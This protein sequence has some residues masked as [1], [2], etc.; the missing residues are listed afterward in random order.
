MEFV[1][2]GLRG[3]ILDETPMIALTTIIVPAAYAPATFYWTGC[4]RQRTILDS[5]VHRRRAYQPAE[6]HSPKHRRD[7]AIGEDGGRSKGERG[8]IW[9]SDPKPQESRSPK[10]AEETYPTLYRKKLRRVQPR[11]RAKETMRRGM[12]RRGAERESRRFC[13]RFIS[14]ATL[15]YP[16]YSDGRK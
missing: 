5:K 9:S 2:C 4:P 1:H 14:A 16:L 12:F 11:E 10:Y 8:E 3:R 7:I 13:V 6:Q 15:I